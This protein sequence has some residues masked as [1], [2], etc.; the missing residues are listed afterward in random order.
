MQIKSREIAP[1]SCWPRS[2][3]SKINKFN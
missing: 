2:T 1:R 3:C